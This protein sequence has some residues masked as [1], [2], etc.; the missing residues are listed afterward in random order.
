MLLPFRQCVVLA[1]VASLFVLCG[2]SWTCGQRAGVARHC[3]LGVRT[4]RHAK[5]GSPNK[6]MMTWE[7]DRKLLKTSVSVHFNSTSC[8]HSHFKVADATMQMV[9][10]R[11][12]FAT[13]VSFLLL[14]FLHRCLSTTVLF[15]FPLHP[16]H[17]KTRTHVK[18][19]SGTPLR[20]PSTTD[21]KDLLI[22]MR[23]DER[24]VG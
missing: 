23:D 17:T 11:E 12:R 16:H 2:I 6:Y 21:G 7:R 3:S 4:S 14:F 5:T 8:H 10:R 1:L 19:T 24:V 9:T 20:R 15:L 18:A 22:G 13:R